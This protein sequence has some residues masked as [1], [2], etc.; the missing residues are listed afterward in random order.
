MKK[1]SK[2]TGEEIGSEKSVERKVTEVDLLKAGIKKLMDNYLTVRYYGPGNRY[3]NAGTTKVE[4]KEIFLEALLDL[5][6]EVSTKD[7]IKLMEGLKLKSNDWK[8]IDDKIEELNESL[9][10]VEGSKLVSHKN[11]IK[12]IIKKYKGD[13]FILEHI[14]NTS[15][16]LSDESKKLRIS[17]IEDMLKKGEIDK[18]YSKLIE[19]YL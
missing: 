8:L 10:K 16:K 3:Q 15:S 2:I 4:G 6:E 19:Y 7:K 9:T 12:S 18:K 17:A 1:F 11:K 5:L 14:K 13:D